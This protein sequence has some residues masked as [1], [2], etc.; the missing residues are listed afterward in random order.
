M[1]NRQCADPCPGCGQKDQWRKKHEY[2]DDCQRL[3]KDAY[4]ALELKGN[5]KDVVTVLIPKASH[6]IKYIPHPGSQDD[7]RGAIHRLALCAGEVLPAVNWDQKHERLDDECSS[8][9]CLAVRMPRDVYTAIKEVIAT[10]HDSIDKAFKDGRQE[11][12]NH[13]KQLATGDMTVKEFNKYSI[14]QRS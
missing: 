7:P 3:L 1:H 12:M 6:W 13:L 8:S 11:G 4:E 14:K 5:K 2:C 9:S 10:L